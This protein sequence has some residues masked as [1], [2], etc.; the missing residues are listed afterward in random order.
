M[1]LEADSLV[2]Q[3]KPKCPLTVEIPF[4]SQVSLLP[5][6]SLESSSIPPTTTSDSSLPTLNV[7]FAP[8]PQLL[9]RKRRSSVPLGMAGRGQ[10]V[11]RRSGYKAFPMWTDEGPEEYRLQQEE[12]AARHA[13]SNAYAVYAA[14]RKEEDEDEPESEYD[15]HCRKNGEDEG[16]TLQTLGRIVKGASKTLWKRVLSKDVAAAATATSKDQEDSYKS[17]MDDRHIEEEEGGVW[18]EEI[19]TS[20]LHNVSQTET[21]VEG[22]VYSRFT[23]K[24]EV[25]TRSPPPSPGV[26]N[27]NRMSSFTKRPSLKKVPPLFKAK[28]G[29]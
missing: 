14:A 20:F 21:V 27:L 8:L 3:S 23:S 29:S 22:R 19:G 9:P 5:P 12:L 15:W 6:P 18:E 4:N 10:L 25:L 16:D 2:S 17:S 1:A 13:R 11:P 28:E 24:V 26:L 7:K